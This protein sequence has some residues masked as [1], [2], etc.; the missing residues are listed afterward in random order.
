MSVTD[1]LREHITAHLSAALPD[2]GGWRTLPA[3]DLA[4]ILAGT[5]MSA[6]S[7]ALADMTAV[8][9]ALAVIAD[10]AGLPAGG[11]V[12][13]IADEVTSVLAGSHFVPEPDETDYPGRFRR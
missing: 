9:D 5:V 10:S 7:P 11:T 1:E 3:P 2:D 6:I 13:V 8:Q 4:A 12:A